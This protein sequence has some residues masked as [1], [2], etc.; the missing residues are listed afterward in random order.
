MK[1]VIFWM[2]EEIKKADILTD[3]G[4]FQLLHF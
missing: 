1:R 2:K 4:L 3:I